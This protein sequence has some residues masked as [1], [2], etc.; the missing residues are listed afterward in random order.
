[1]T[2]SWLRLP[3]SV[4]LLFLVRVCFLSPFPIQQHHLSI[5]TT[6]RKTEKSQ[7]H[8]SKKSPVSFIPSDPL[9]SVFLL[10]EFRSFLCG[11]FLK[12]FLGLSASF[13]GNGL[14]N[15]PAPDLKPQKTAAVFWTK[16][17]SLRVRVCCV[18]W[19]CVF[20]AYESSKSSTKRLPG[21]KGNI[22]ERVLECRPYT[23]LRQAVV[24]RCSV[25]LI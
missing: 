7:K 25:F 11:R 10:R 12:F 14:P 5:T 23:E 13:A 22:K 1:M 20:L 21:V 9:L 24:G 3:V 6:S 2:F 19:C 8:R 17:R 4:L 16:K 18:P 15:R